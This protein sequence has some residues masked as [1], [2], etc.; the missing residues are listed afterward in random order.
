MDPLGPGMFAV[1]VMAAALTTAAAILRIRA[2]K[3]EA[4]DLKAPT[5]WPKPK[6]GTCPRCGGTRTGR[7]CARCGVRL[8]LGV[9]FRGRLF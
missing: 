5:S 2:A 7:H 3:R 9:S 1:Q 8:R 4:A 6:G